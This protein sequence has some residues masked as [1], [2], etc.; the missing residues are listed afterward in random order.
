FRDLLAGVDPEQLYKGIGKLVVVEGILDR[1]MDDPQLI[2]ES[3]NSTGMDLS[4][5]DLIRNFVLMRVTEREQTRHFDTYWTKIEA[6]FRG[7]EKV[8]DAFIRD[9]VALQTRASKQDRSDEIY[10]SFRRY[11]AARD[12]RNEELDEFLGELLTFARYHAA[13][14]LGTGAPASLRDQLARL[15]RKVDV[16]ALLLMRLFDCYS[17]QK[18]LAEAEF[19]QAL[20][21]VDS[22]V[23]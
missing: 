11:F 4:Q 10:F 8:F 18:T 23:M 6:L 3:M 19:G 7:S 22:Y 16:P 21:L 1:T 15:R 13:F 2:F 14:S 12:V 5:S 20:D 9:Y 17:S